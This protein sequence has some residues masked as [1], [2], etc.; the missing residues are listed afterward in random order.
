MLTSQN[1]KYTI[2]IQFV[3]IQDHDKQMYGCT[4]TALSPHE[5]NYDLCAIMGA[6]QK[7]WIVQCY[8]CKTV[9][10]VPKKDFTITNI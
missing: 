5:K 2:S 7:G 8:I 3:R 9:Y 10:G 6:R 4:G 1:G